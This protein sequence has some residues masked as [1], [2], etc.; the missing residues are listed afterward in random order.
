M[1]FDHDS[2]HAGCSSDTYGYT[3]GGVDHAENG[4][5]IDKFSFSSDGDATGVGNLTVGGYGQFGTSSTTYGYA[6]G[7]YR[8]AAYSNIIEKWS[9]SSD[10]DSSDVGNLT[11]GTGEGNNAASSTT[12]GYV[13]GGY[14]S[15]PGVVNTI[16]K[17][18]F[19]SD[20]SHP[21][22]EILV[23][24]TSNRSWPQMAEAI[25]SIVYNVSNS[26]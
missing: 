24:M 17:H 22:V 5:P 6:S 25:D 12:F 15:G 11:V 8:S 20:A 14:V 26:P 10:E 7:G 1:S 13:A 19:S 2:M 18:S 3:A 4:K 23:M 21:A 9:F 16:Q